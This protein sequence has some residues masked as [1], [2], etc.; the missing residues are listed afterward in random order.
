MLS[1]LGTQVVLYCHRCLIYNDGDAVCRT[2]DEEVVQEEPTL[3]TQPLVATA[4]VRMIVMLLLLASTL[5]LVIVGCVIN[6]FEVIDSQAGVTVPT[7]YSVLSV[8]SRVPSASLE[9]NSIGVRWIQAMY[10][11][12]VLHCHCGL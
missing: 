4:R 7:V 10:F 6:V 1:L 9:P 3:G 5:A 8:G 12:R 2:D 11:L